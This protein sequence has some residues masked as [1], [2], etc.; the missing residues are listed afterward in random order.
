MLFKFFRKYNFCIKKTFLNTRNVLMENIN[1][2]GI[3]IVRSKE[4]AIKAV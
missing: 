1:I 3:T 4:D 2:A